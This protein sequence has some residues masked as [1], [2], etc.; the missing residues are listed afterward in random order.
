MGI[1]TKI[2]PQS[3]YT[4]AGCGGGDGVNFRCIAIEPGG[5][6]Q[7]G[8][9]H[10]SRRSPDHVRRTPFEF[11]W[12]RANFNTAP[13]FLNSNEPAFLEFALVRAVRSRPARCLYGPCNP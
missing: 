13:D 10:G 11:V 5:R 7:S 12:D 4:D 3:G 6:Q 1:Y 2:V 8:P 9:L